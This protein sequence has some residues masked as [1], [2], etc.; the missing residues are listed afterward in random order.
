MWFS[1]LYTL[2]V[3]QRIV[4]LRI[5]KK[6]ERWMKDKGA[7]EVGRSHYKYIVALHVLFFISLFIEVQ[8]GR[9]DLA[10]WWFIP[11]VFF[12][13]A[14]CLRVWSILSLGRFWNTRILILPGTNVVTKGPYRFMRH[15]NYFIVITEILVVPLIF[16][17]YFTAILFTLLNAMLLSVRIPIEE[18]ALMEA[19][20][21]R[22]IFIEKSR[23]IP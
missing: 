7:Y 4:E 22:D 8:I 13:M 18:R 21:Y 1:I 20:N 5:A 6:N 16:Q 10:S 11:F 15:P 19:T 14:Q 9:R 2:L 12:I 17:A 3:L 23:F